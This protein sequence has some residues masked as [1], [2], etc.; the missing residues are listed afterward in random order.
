[1]FKLKHL[2]SI[3]SL[4]IIFYLAI[5]TSAMEVKENCFECARSNSGRNYMCDGNGRLP[6]NNM[7]A[8]ACCNP[9]DGHEFCQRSETN[10]CSPTYNDAQHNFYTH[11]PLINSTGCGIQNSKKSDFS[12]EAST[13]PQ[14]F[15]FSNLRYKKAEWKYYSADV[16]YFQV[17]NPSYYYS[18]G[19][20]FITFT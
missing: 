2:R 11:C 7:Y 5:S 13:Q 15:S 14:T 6:G 17:M 18:T 9:D 20:V 16:C 3:S 1:M 10:K 19:K 8:V 4:M 12:I